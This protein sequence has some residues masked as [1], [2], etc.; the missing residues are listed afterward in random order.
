MEARGGPTRRAVDILL[1]PSDCGAARVMICIQ[2]QILILVLQYAC[3]LCTSTNEAPH[4][5][6]LRPRCSPS[7]DLIHSGV[8][9]SGSG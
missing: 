2:K 4:W 1:M 7:P 5:S 9:G 8:T 3:T 6:R